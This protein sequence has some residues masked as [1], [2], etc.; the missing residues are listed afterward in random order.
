MGFCDGY[1][2]YK[3]TFLPG[4][5]IV[6]ITSHLDRLVESAREEVVGVVHVGTCGT[7]RHEQHV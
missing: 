5:K 3:M 4:T 6:D 1:V 7:C 2:D